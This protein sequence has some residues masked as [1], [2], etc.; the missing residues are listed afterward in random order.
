MAAIDINLPGPERRSRGLL[1]DVA[2]LIPASWFEERNAGRWA[3]G[4]TWLPHGIANITTDG[5]ACE[6][7]YDKNARDLPDIATQSSFLIYDSVRCSTLSSNVAWLTALLRHN[8]GAGNAEGV[9]VS[10]AFAAELETGAQSNGSISLTGN[11]TNPP[12]ILSNTAVGLDIA[13]DLLEEHLAAVLHGAAGV[14]HLTPGLLTIAVADGLVEWREGQYQ[15][16]TGH[17]VVGDAGHSGT[18]TPEGGSAAGAGEVWAYATGEVWYLLSNTDGFESSVDGDSQTY[19]LRNENRPLVER[20][21]LVAFD[22]E[23]LG[24]VKVS[25]G[26]SDGGSSTGGGGGGGGGGAS[27]ANQT[28]G[29]TTLTAIDGRLANVEDALTADSATLSNVNDTVASTTLLAANAARRGVTIFNDSTADLFVKYG[30][31]ASATSFTVKIAGGGYWEMPSPT[32]LGVLDGIWSADTA[33]GAAR[34]TE[35]T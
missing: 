35:L 29:N 34:V 21:G 25:I 24:A 26:A 2:R 11:A 33:S 13:F 4:L 31:T 19:L 32:Y 22:P 6:L 28:A 5:A 18:V 7:T 16:P 20:Y 12:E 10:A 15:T 17:S 8:L 3:D 27:A 1:L 30:A 23:T 14:I 9:Y